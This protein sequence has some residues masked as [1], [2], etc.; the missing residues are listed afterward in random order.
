MGSTIFQ[1]CL[2]SPRKQLRGTHNALH[3]WVDGPTII[4]RLVLVRVFNVRV[5]VR[6]IRFHCESEC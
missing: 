3:A 1:A 2:L 4:S 6:M 5:Y